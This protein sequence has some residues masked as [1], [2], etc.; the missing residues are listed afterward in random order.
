MKED[1]STDLERNDGE[2]P[3]SL[4]RREFLKAVGGGIII[5]FSTEDLNRP[6]KTTAR[7]PGFT[8]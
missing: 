4:N 7:L 1:Q 2:A 6:G 3:F 8:R 5:F